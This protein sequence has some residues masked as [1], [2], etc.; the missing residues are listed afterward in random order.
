MSRTTQT[1]L[2]HYGGAVVFTALAVLVRSL[3]DP[4]VGDYLPLATLYGA[5][6]FAAWLGGYRPALLAVILGFL[7]CDYLFIEARGKV[8][9][10]DARNLVGL[11]PYLYSCAVIIAFG[12]AL[13]AARRRA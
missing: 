4:V 11:I 9:L 10:L 3:L 13:R 6:A 2:L 5:V 12:E 1:I 8:L 7:A